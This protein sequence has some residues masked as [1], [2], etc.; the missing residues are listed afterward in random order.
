VCHGAATPAGYVTDNTDCNDGNPG[1]HPGA[2]E[3]CNGIDDNCNT[4]IDEGFDQDGDGY[5]TCG[6]DCNDANPAIH[7]GASDAN[8]DG[9]DN[10]CNGQIDEGYVG[11]ATNCGVGA[12]RRT[13]A[14]S[15]VNGQVVNSC[16]PGTPAPD[17][18]SCNGID[19][20][21]NGLVDDGYVPVATNCGIGACARTGATSCVGGHVTDSCVPGA[22]V[23]ETCNGIDDDCN[24]VVDNVAAPTGTLSL[25]VAT[26]TGETLLSWGASSAATGYDALSGDLQELR[27]NAGNYGSLALASCLGNDVAA[28]TLSAGSGSPAPGA[29]E[30]FLVRAVNCG[31]NGTYD[32]GG[33]RLSA[34]RDGGIQS[35][36]YA[37]P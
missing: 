24:G 2:T 35:G 7:P 8:C 32:D 5:T 25:T 27:G 13:G 29:A 20:D 22:P 15:C 10:N 3:V 6:G 18:A 14:T 23:A 34:P 19:D 30:W 1:V 26:V 4:L 17:D 9:V 16:V 33:P 21:C 37:C 31:G 28:T 11:H 36:G 12:C